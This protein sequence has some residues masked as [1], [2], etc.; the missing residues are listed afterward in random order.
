MI[1]FD[2]ESRF[3][4]GVAEK[5]IIQSCDSKSDS[6]HTATMLFMKPSKR[7]ASTVTERD[8]EVDVLYI[9]LPFPNL[10][11]QSLSCSAV[12]LIRKSGDENKVIDLDFTHD[13]Q[14][15]SCAR[16]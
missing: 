14:E 6:R 7:S 12:D 5:I 3:S 1:F 2:R 10:T 8:E 11:T 4:Y 9:S 13:L 16:E 15:A